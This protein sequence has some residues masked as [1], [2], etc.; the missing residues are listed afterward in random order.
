M[1]TEPHCKYAVRHKSKLDSLTFF[2]MASVRKESLFERSYYRMD[3]AAGKGISGTYEKN[4]VDCTAKTRAFGG[5]HSFLDSI[6]YC[7]ITVTSYS[8]AAR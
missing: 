3:R 8:V 6:I 4:T 7:N 5:R 1:L 2:A